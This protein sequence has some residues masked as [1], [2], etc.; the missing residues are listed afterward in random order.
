MRSESRKSRRESMSNDGGNGEEVREF[1]L[2][3]ATLVVAAV[4][5]VVALG[6]AFML[7]RWVERDGDGSAALKPR[8]TA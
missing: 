5:L 7:G 1:R 3:G 2:E 4:V 6:A 8:R